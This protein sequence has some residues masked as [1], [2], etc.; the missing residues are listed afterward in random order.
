MILITGARY[1]GQK[2]YITDALHLGDAEFEACAV[3]EVQDLLR[4]CE[5]VDSVFEL[6]RNKRIVIASEVGCGVVPLDKDER[7]FRERAGELAQRLAKEAD[8]VIRTVCGLPQFIK[9]EL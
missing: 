5:D 3:C 7:M 8:T 2:E 4:E 6:V 1:S 9:G